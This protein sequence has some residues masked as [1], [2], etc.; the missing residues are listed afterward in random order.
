MIIK[1]IEKGTYKN[2]LFLSL[3][4]LLNLQ[5][6]SNE[7]IKEQL[8]FTEIKDG[9]NFFKFLYEHAMPE[10]LTLNEEKKEEL[11][12]TEN[13]DTNKSEEK[14][15]SQSQSEDKFILLENIKKK[16]KGEPDD[17]ITEEL[18]Q[19]C[20][21]FLLNCFNNTSNPKNF[22]IIKYNLS[23]KKIRQKT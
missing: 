22:S 17:N 7:E 16:K 4:Q 14:E 11:I 20:N 5:I 12:S 2:K 10:L 1:N 21:E 3:L 6:S 23:P 18:S 19:I 9:E 13:N 15:Q 8:L